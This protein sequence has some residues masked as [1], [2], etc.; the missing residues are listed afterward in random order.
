MV[1]HD[2]DGAIDQG[3]FTVAERT[4]ADQS[5]LLLTAAVAQRVDDPFDAAAGGVDRLQGRVLSQH[6]FRHGPGDIRP[7]MTANRLKDLLPLALF[8][9]AGA[10]ADLTAFLAGKTIIA[11][12]NAN[13][14]IPPA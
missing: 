8:S 1:K 10:K 4:V 9:Q 3:Q 6:L 2:V 12:D 13:F 11:N 5:D 7:F 14:T